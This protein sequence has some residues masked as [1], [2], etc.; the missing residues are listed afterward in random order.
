MY[1][2]M[3]LPI[4]TERGFA[5]PAVA[6]PVSPA[7]GVSRARALEAA[8]GIHILERGPR[9]IVNQGEVECCV[10]CA[11]G[12]AMEILR[13]DWPALAPIFHYHL[14][15]QNGGAD[16]QGRLFLSSAFETLKRQGI[17]TEAVHSH[18]FTP[19]GAAVPPTA[20]ALEDG[21]GRR[22]LLNGLF[23]PFQ[24]IGGTS[25]VAGIREHLKKQHPVVIGF[26]LPEKYPDSLEKDKEWLDTRRLAPSASHHCVLVIGFND[27]K[28]AVRVADSQGRARFEQGEWWLGYRIVDSDLVQD[29]YALT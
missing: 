3:P 23:F 4:T 9:R 10:S 26:T 29:A 21:L 1:F 18:P 17:C 24:R 28:G 15:R 25:L 5:P 11:L 13:P 14:T 8:P 7:A 22:L 27:L 19:A 16:G 20:A 6:A 12:G 2:R